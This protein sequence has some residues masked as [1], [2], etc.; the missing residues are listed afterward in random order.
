[1]LTGQRQAHLVAAG[2]GHIEAGRRVVEVPIPAGLC[3]ARRVAAGTEHIEAGRQV[4]EVPLPAGLCQ[5]HR[6]ADPVA[7]DTAALL[8][9]AD[10]A[11]ATPEADRRIATLLMADTTVAN[12]FHPASPHTS[13]TVRRLQREPPALPEHYGGDGGTDFAMAAPRV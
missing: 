3:Q 7:V 6:V 8:R 13:L 2:T 1:M 10:R 4:V 11:E 9:E 5:A 12:D